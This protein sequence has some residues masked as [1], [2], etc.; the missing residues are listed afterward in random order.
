MGQQ[1]GTGVILAKIGRMPFALQPF[2]PQPFVARENL[3]KNS[4][5]AGG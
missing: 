1:W 2:A 5:R 3:G 4:N